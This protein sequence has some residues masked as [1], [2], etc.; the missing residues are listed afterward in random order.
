METID[1]T[2]EEYLVFLEDKYFVVTYGSAVGGNDGNSGSVTIKFNDEITS[3]KAGMTQRVLKTK[4]DYL[5]ILNILSNETSGW[6]SAPYKKELGTGVGCFQL[7]NII[8]AL[9]E[10]Y[11]AR[12]DAEEYLAN[13]PE[14]LISKLSN[15]LNMQQK[16]MIIQSKVIKDLDWDL[17]NVF[18]ASSKKVKNLIRMLFKGHSYKGFLTSLDKV[19]SEDKD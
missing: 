9:P 19:I 12:L 6:C 5:V 13:N 4:D 7:G 8:K 14:M 16:A 15:V 18:P 17:S 11:R 1:K 3:E 10:S 2:W